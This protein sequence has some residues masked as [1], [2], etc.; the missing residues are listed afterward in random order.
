[1]PDMQSVAECSEEGEMGWTKWIDSKF[2]D[3]IDAS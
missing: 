3:S 1:M 2:H